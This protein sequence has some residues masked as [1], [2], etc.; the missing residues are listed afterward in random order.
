MN[1]YNLKPMKKNDLKTRLE[2]GGKVYNDEISRYEASFIY[3]LNHYTI[4]D[5]MRE[6]RD[7]YKLPPKNRKEQ[8]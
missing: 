5:Y 2:I 1:I 8:K 6:Y 3:H 7:Y 4:R